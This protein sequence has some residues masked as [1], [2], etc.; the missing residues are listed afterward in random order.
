MTVSGKGSLEKAGPPSSAREGPSRAAV[1]RCIA[2]PEAA[3][4]MF[5]R[6]KLQESFQMNK[7]P[8]G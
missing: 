2:C 1:D 6:G 8:A 4:P 5:E 3:E 7:R